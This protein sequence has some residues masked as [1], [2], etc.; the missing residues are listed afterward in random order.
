MTAKLPAPPAAPTLDVRD[1]D[2]FMV[3]V[4]EITASEFSATSTGD[5]FKAAFVLRAKAWKQQPAGSLPD[6]DRAL[7]AFAGLALPK[8]RKI[9]QRALTGFVKCS[10]GRL[11]HPELVA[12]AQRAATNRD[13]ARVKREADAQR[14]REWRNAKKGNVNETRFNGV[15]DAFHETPETRDVASIPVPIPIPSSSPSPL[16][17]ASPRADLMLKVWSAIGVPDAAAVPPQLVGGLF[18][19]VVSLE[20]E[21]C[22]FDSDIATALRC[23]PQGAAW[24]VSVA[25]WRKIA[26]SNRDSR[27]ASAASAQPV[28]IGVWRDRLDVWNNKDG[29]WSPA[30][31][32]KP[33][34]VG[35]LVPPSLRN[36]AAAHG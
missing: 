13:K 4:D 34:E 27:A 23:R 35:C 7:A 6:D 33:D 9:R 10:D 14:L 26:R 5:E 28:E 22:E 29:K 24:P 21:G 20:A 18:D 3:N 16:S 11:Y 36:G 2:G 1:V 15:S 12:D 31:G 25:F 19:L 32:P 8:W 17:P 30:W